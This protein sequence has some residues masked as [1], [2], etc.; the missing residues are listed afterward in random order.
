MVNS[1]EEKFQEAYHR[2]YT[3]FSKNLQTLPNKQSVT[4]NSL[5]KPNDIWWNLWKFWK[6]LPIQ[7]LHLTIL[8]NKHLS[9]FCETKQ[10]K[11]VYKNL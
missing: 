10:F 1:E 7:M 2:S 8:K 5:C 3:F 6:N 9:C 11:S 4:P